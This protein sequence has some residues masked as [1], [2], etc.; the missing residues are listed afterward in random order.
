VQRADT[1]ETKEHNDARDRIKKERDLIWKY[2]LRRP[3][4]VLKPESTQGKYVSEGADIRVTRGS[5]C[6]KVSGVEGIGQRCALSVDCGYYPVERA[7]KDSTGKYRAARECRTRARV[8]A[9]PH[10]FHD[11][12]KKEESDNEASNDKEMY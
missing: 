7:H 6:F 10:C 5:E 11:I 3:H 4:F 2:K 8:L 12:A 1:V 9:F